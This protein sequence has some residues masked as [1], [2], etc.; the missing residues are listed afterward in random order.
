MQMQNNQE[1]NEQA[2]T[3]VR[4][5]HLEVLNWGTFNGKVYTIRQNRLNT[6]LT[7]NI[8]AGKST[9]VDALTALLVPHR[10]ITFNKAAGA[11]HKERDFRSYIYGY[12]G[13]KQDESTGRTKPQSL[14]EK[15]PYSVI[16]A[17]FEEEDPAK[18]YTIAQVFWAKDKQPQKMFVTATGTLSIK[19]NFTSFGKNVSQLRK[20]LNSQSHIEIADSFKDY[21]LAFRK[22]LA[23]RSENVLELFYQTVSMKS[24]GNLTDFVRQQMLEET[25]SENQ[26]KELINNYDNLQKAYLKIQE[27][28]K[29]FELLE[30]IETEGKVYERNLDNEEK[31]RQA[32]SFT[33]AYF[34][35]K[36]LRDITDKQK[37]ESLKSSEIKEK[38]ASVEA[39]IEQL[40]DTQDELKQAIRDN[41]GQRLEDIGKEI[42]RQESIR[43]KKQNKFD[44]YIKLASA[45][46]PETVTKVNE[47]SFVQ[48]R[49]VAESYILL[50]SQKRGEKENILFEVKSDLS[51]VRKEIEQ[52]KQEL[53]SLQSR[54][55]LI[56]KDKLRI[57]SMIMD[58]LS[59]DENDL[60]FVG[61]LIKVK[62]D[63][64]DWQGA[65]ERL[66]NSFGISMIVPEHLYREVSQFVKETHLNGKLVYF[67][68]PDNYEIPSGVYPQASISVVDKVQIKHEDNPYAEWIEHQLIQRFDYFCCEEAEDFYRASMAITKE[69]LIKRGKSLHEK[70][71][72]RRINDQRHYVL[73]WTNKDKILAVQAALDKLLPIEE[74]LVSKEKR[75]TREKK[76]F[77]EQHKGLE[78]LLQYFEHFQEINWHEVANYIQV[79]QEE[80]EKLQQQ[81]GKLK[82]LKEQLTKTKS[83]LSAQKEAHS[84]LLQEY[85]GIEN[86]LKTYRKQANDQKVLLSEITNKEQEL[87]FPL[88]EKYAKKFESTSV[89]H[90]KEKT[91]ITILE[92]LKRLNEK[93]R[94]N[95]VRIGNLMQKF[96]GA[97]PSLTNEM[98]ASTEALP[99]YYRLKK[100]IEKDDLPK[101]EARFKRELNEKTIHG[102]MLFKIGMEDQEKAI[103]ERIQI[104]NDSLT[105]IDYDSTFQT[106][107]ELNSLYNPDHDIKTF[108]LQLKEAMEMMVSEEEQFSEERFQKVKKIIDRFK[109]TESKDIRWTS[110]VTDVRN[111][112][113]FSASERYKETGEEKERYED[114]A[115]K[116]GGQ[117]EKLAYTVLASALAYQ[118]G[119]SFEA[120]NAR[121]FRFVVIDEA[122]GKG[123]NESTR[124]ALKLF[125]QLGLQ[126]LIVTPLQKINVIED[127]IEG[128]HFVSKFGNESVVRDLTKK[129]YKEE[130]AKA[131]ME[132]AV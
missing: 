93:L 103:K 3:G 70:D 80:Q 95:G 44:D 122:F 120:S 7:G 117:K 5:K 87:Y 63:E 114:A 83:D 64:K 21:Q 31:H 25:N 128:V 98:D 17:I 104:I 6:L 51:E 57:R 69:G 47:T 58:A 132:R 100:Q 20:K 116:S 40:E 112:Y 33:P 130:K 34:A 60:P 123:S 49:N 27:A 91:N 126:L 66:L 68:V 52:D 108:R 61:E 81:S 125:E 90:T 24:V 77:E 2:L 45:V 119:L 1:T 37:E 115:G 29:Q 101:H 19:E 10:K 105:N 73:G 94:Q 11:E 56:P 99:D 107:I 74:K 43:A 127:Y 13:R 30:P 86:A 48:N 124:Y 14:R 89:A 8:G 106:F 71:D 36:I 12:Y 41:G 113:T 38:K 35:K 55:N 79:L 76:N 16:L 39:Q 121:S 102:L 109:S 22:L 85:G 53:A 50:L 111:W 129:E 75:L 59:L 26:I 28:R 82:A 88:I 54:K 32:Q 84:R 15:A 97:Y 96:K 4:L 42:K 18:T 92:T 67:K 9:L 78:N 72:R 131:E 46:L 23:I 110:K 62:D 118:Y 65:I